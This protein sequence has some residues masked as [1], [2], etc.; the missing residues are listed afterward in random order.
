MTFR[1]EAIALMTVLLQAGL[2]RISPAAMKAANMRV[3]RSRVFSLL[4]EDSAMVRAVEERGARKS[5]TLKRML[6]FCD[7]GTEAAWLS[8]VNG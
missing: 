6:G 3:R 1:S 2:P 5:E 4:S 8:A 7:A